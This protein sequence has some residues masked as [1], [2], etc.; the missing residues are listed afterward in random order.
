MIHIEYVDC[1]KFT[2]EKFEN[3]QEFKEKLESLDIDSYFLPNEV[4][5]LESGNV[6]YVTTNP[7]SSEI[8]HETSFLY[9]NNKETLRAQRDLCSEE[10]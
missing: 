7:Y 3:V 1:E 4:K 6:T 8:D 9:S 10:I 5:L 2:K